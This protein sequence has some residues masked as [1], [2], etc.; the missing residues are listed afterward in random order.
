MDVVAVILAKRNPGAAKHQEV[1]A[2]QNSLGNKSSGRL[3]II[4][5]FQ[6]KTGVLYFFILIQVT[7]HPT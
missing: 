5:H 4:T 2:V 6:Q 1:V 3:N 7:S